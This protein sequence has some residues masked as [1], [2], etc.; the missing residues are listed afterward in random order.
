MKHIKQ[1]ISYSMVGSL[2]LTIVAGLQ[3]CEQAP[4]NAGTQ[5]FDSAQSA[6]QAQ[7]FFIVM[8]QTGSNPDTY[9]L[10][11]KHPTSG[12]TRAVLRLADGTERFMSDQ[13]LKKIAEQEAARVDAGESRLT[14]DPSMYSGGM[15]MGEL[16]LA[17]AAGAL[18]GGMLA[19]RLSRNQN[20]QRTQTRYGGGRPTAAIS[21]PFRQ[22]ANT[23]Q[24]RSG[25]F[26]GPNKSA[27]GGSRFGTF[28][29]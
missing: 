3:G 29:G 7:N 4:P 5:G 24:A 20:F 2:G 27:S 11:E 1:A 15:S 10:V 26:G 22:S 12:S 13:E 21:Q 19:N 28:G 16:L 8:E 9:K 6:G 17:S 25:F 23:K 18:V 14:G